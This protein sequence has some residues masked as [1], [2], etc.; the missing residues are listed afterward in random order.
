[1]P[2][3]SHKDLAGLHKTLQSITET[4]ARRL[5]ILAGDFNCPDIDWD[6]ASVAPNAPDRQT[7][8]ELIDVSTSAQLSQVHHQATREENILD[9]VFTTNPSLSKS[10]SSIPGISD[11]QAVVTDFDTKPQRIQ[12]KWR[13]LYLYSKAKWDDLNAEIDELSKKILKMKNE[14]ADVES[15]WKEFKTSI[16]SA[17][18]RCVPSKLQRPSTNLP[19]IN[20]RIKR[21]MQRKKRLYKQAKK[22]GHWGNYKFFQRECR[23]EMRRTEWEYI[24]TTIEE[25]LKENNSKPFWRYI[26]SRRQDNVGVSPLKKGPSLFSDSLSKAQILLEQFCS[27]FTR[28]DDAPP[29]EM[30]S[31]SSPTLNDLT[32]DVNGVAKLLRNINTS[33]APGPDGIPNKILKTCADAIAPPLTCIFNCSITTGQ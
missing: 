32:I 31:P 14:D 2:K 13:R 30:K 19:W 15:M 21:L 26:K 12:Q 20:R 33:K 17:V 9:L 27:V 8:Q 11:H 28:D 24:N 16:M 23:R 5:V 10:S 25:G 29:P 3:R 4:Q 7:Q 1:M 18:E 6:T 22:T